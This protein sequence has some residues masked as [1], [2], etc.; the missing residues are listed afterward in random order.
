MHLVNGTGN[1]PVSGT[2]DPR[3]SQTAGLRNT[4]FRNVTVHLSPKWADLW[5][6]GENGGK[7]GKFWTLDEKKGNEKVKKHDFDWQQGYGGGGGVALVK[8]LEEKWGGMGGKWENQT[9]PP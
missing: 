8:A 6:I 9:T 2:A 4:R 7:C 5:K 1:S 3:S